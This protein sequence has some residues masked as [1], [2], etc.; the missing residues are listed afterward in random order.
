MNQ[1]STLTEHF[2]VTVDR[3][4]PMTDCA[5]HGVPE[6]VRQG[7]PLNLTASVLV[8]VAVDVSFWWVLSCWALIKCEDLPS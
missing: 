2:N 4:N 1:V 5:V 6:I 8:D 7:S 3:M